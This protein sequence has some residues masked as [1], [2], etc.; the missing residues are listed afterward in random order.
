MRV[1]K[2][3][4]DCNILIRYFTGNRHTFLVDI[5]E[6]FPDIK[7]YYCQELL[8]EFMR[9]AKYSRLAK[10]NIDVK[11]SIEFIKDFF[12]EHKLHKPIKHRVATDPNDDFVLALALETNS[13]YLVS[14]DIEAFHNNKELF[15]KKYPHLKFLKKTEFEKLFTDKLQKLKN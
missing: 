6:N 2:F 15:Q 1:N 13:G 12:I 5:F 3:V 8:D 10:A 14:D 11:K 9:V 4:L 7:F